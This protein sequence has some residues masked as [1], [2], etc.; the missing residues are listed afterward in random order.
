[1]EKENQRV[2]MSKRLLSEGLMRLA[3]KKSVDKISV[4][5][6]C[7][8]SGINRATFYRHYE[9]PR[10]ILVEMEKELFNEIFEEI[11]F[12]VSIQD[13]ER[14]LED[15]CLYLEGRIEKLRILILSNT[16]TLFVQVLKDIYIEFFHNKSGIQA[17]KNFDSENFEVLGL[18]CSG[19]SYY[20]LRHWLLGEIKKTPKEISAIAY[21]LL[22]KTNLED[23]IMQ[24]S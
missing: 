17:F 13:V 8:E 3:K 10:D 9:T 19:G 11:A 22:I 15:I 16:D 1:M 24:L 6:L 5:E 14:Y 20:I 4:L 21:Q 18:Y 7:K 2:T 12:P 23:T